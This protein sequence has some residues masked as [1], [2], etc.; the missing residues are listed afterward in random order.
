MEKQHIYLD[1]SATTPLSKAARNAIDTAAE[2]F[3][4][5]SSLHTLGQ[6]AHALVEKA[7]EEIALSLG[8][9]RGTGSIIFT[10]C[11]TEA[12]STALFG[13]AYAK[14]RRTATR[15]LTTDSEHH[16]TSEA[17][18]ALESDGF[19]IVKIPTRGGVLDMGALE[20]ALETPVFLASFMLVNNETGALYDVARAFARIKSRYPD[21]ITHCDAIQ[22]FMRVKFTP[23]SLSADLVSVSGHK[24]HAPK[25]VGALYVSQDLIRAKKIVPFLR[26]GGQ[27]MGLRSGTENVLGIAAFGASAADM[28]ARREQLEKTLKDLYD[29]T[30]LSLSRLDVQINV[31]TGNRVNHI[32]NVTLPSI[33][34]ETMLHFL[35]ADG[36]FVSSGSACASHS[37]APSAALLAFG[38]SKAEADTSIRISLSEYNTIDDIDALC[39]SLFCGISRLVRIRG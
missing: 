19:E 9:R 23:A 29:Y 38:L 20:S 10:S 17:L 35:S 15:I 32:I 37:N 27:E 22:G 3:G 2:C 31:P 14:K 16:A 26:G 21:A 7:R 39:S 36:I 33:K 18:G 13:T 6:S 11:G 1:N 5:P 30:V 24:I 4:N 25:G 8:V 28:N 34:S 12:I